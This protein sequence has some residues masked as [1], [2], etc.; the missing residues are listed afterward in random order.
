MSACVCSFLGAIY[1]LKLPKDSLS[2]D[3][4]RRHPPTPFAGVTLS[5]HPLPEEAKE[6]LHL[7]YCGATGEDGK[8][9]V[10]ARTQ[11]KRP[12]VKYIPFQ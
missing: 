11:R 1:R 2:P 4:P 3:A 5:A 8:T 9:L 10:S 12:S 7:P 6:P